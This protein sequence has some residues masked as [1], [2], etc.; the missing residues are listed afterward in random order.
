M[1][2][3]LILETPSESEEQHRT[4]IVRSRY[5]RFSHAGSERFLPTTN[6]RNYAQNEGVESYNRLDR[7]NKRTGTSMAWGDVRLPT[8]IG[9]GMV[10]QR[11]AA[12]R[13]WGWAD[14]GEKVRIDFHGATSTVKADKTGQWSTSLGPFI[15]GGPYEMKIRGNKEV[16]LRDIL[17]GDVW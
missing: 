1:V 8:L 4:T 10:L 6:R 12:V 17:I 9:D 15:A 16:K 13:V 2:V 3:S 14:Q 5:Y 7:C 11:D